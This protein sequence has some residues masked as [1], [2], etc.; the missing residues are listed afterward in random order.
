MLWLLFEVVISRSLLVVVAVLV[1][2]SAILPLDW[3]WLSLHIVAAVVTSV[4]LDRSNPSM[5]IVG[6]LLALFI[7]SIFLISENGRLH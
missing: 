5:W 4:G 6:L 7:L 3:C 1:A 2:M